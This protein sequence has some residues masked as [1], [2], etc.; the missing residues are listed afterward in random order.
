MRGWT[1]LMHLCDFSPQL[2][3]QPHW[4]APLLLAQAGRRRCSGE[5]ALVSLLA[6]PR[7]ALVDFA[8]DWFRRLFYTEASIT[9]HRGW[10]AL[11]TLCAY[12]PQLLA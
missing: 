10:T 1:P 7:A 9:S 5:S 3:N 4:F 2:L 12:N 11:M 8:S 6:S